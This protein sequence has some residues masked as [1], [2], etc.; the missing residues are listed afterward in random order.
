[1]DWDYIG[2]I[3]SIVAA[4][5]TPFAVFLAWSQLEVAQRGPDRQALE[6]R[7][8]LFD[9]VDEMQRFTYF[10]RV[11]GPGAFYDLEAYVHFGNRWHEIS[12]G[13]I[14]FNRFY[15]P[16]EG[17]IAI[18]QKYANEAKLVL[19]WASGAKRNQGLDDHLGMVM[20]SSK[21]RYRWKEKIFAK[22]RKRW[23]R[24]V[25]RFYSDDH[26]LIRPTGKWV[27]LPKDS[28]SG[29][30]HPGWPNT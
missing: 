3:A 19:H 15:D 27:K 26:F 12:E 18:P 1:M 9:P 5:G 29:R 10:I 25:S 16:I 28:V 13:L 21:E 14:E 23:N 30:S 2:T 7:I 6:V 11:V 17:D 22:T 20:I 4:V 24:V 8:R